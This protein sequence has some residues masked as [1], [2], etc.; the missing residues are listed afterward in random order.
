MNKENEVFNILDNELGEFISGDKLREI[1]SQIIALEQGQTYPLDVV[2][3]SLRDDHE[4]LQKNYDII[5]KQYDKRGEI[6]QD[7][8]KKYK[9]PIVNACLDNEQQPLTGE[10]KNSGDTKNKTL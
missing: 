10:Y 1:C 2:S 6:M 9:L 3:G 4:K 7:W 8:I 5:K